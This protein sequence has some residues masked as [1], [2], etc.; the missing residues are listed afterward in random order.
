M[1]LLPELY[2]DIILRSGGVPLL[3]RISKQLS[4]LY[5]NLINEYDIVS[6]PI[7]CREMR[8]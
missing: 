2:G 5:H 6:A 8:K 3:K 4:I 1:I 7:T